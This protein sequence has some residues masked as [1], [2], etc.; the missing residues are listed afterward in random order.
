MVVTEPKQAASPQAASPQAGAEPDSD[1]QDDAKLNVPHWFHGHQLFVESL[2]WHP[3]A[4]YL[5]SGSA[6]GTVRIWNA[7]SFKE[8]RQLLGHSGGVYAAAWDRDG[9]RVVSGGLPEDAMRVWD[10]SNLGKP[11]FDRELQDRP[12]LAWHPDSDQLFVAEKHNVV[13]QNR[14][15]DMR[16]LVAGESSPEVIFAID[17]DNDAGLVACVSGAGRIWTID[18]DDG[19]LQ[20]VFDPGDDKLHFPEIT[21]RGVEW[22]PGGRYLAGVGSGGRVRV[23]DA[24]TK[25]AIAKSELDDAAKGKISVLAWTPT[26]APPPTF[27][28]RGRGRLGVRI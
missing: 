28:V 9:E 17:V 10:V 4:H 19:E 2:V 20:H 8:V 27:G 1:P 26:T 24:A 22:S 3:K 7:D 6:D 13:V 23:W 15:G 5:L 21:C 11:A 16:R 18:A 25:T 14:Q 12:A